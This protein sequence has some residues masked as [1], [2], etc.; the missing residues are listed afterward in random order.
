[1]IINPRFLCPPVSLSTPAS[2]FDAQRNAVLGFQSCTTFAQRSTA[3]NLVNI[4]KHLLK[5]VMKS[6]HPQQGLFN[7]C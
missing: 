2:D 4:I 6:P 7:G 1:M 5:E 3:E